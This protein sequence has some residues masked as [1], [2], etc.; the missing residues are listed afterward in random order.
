MTND[1]YTTMVDVGFNANVMAKVLTTAMDNLPYDQ[2]VQELVDT[3]YFSALML[4]TMLD[5][6]QAGQLTGRILT[7]ALY[8]AS[9]ANAVF[10]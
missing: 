4:M 8:Q 9:K 6:K 1:N 10:V 2:A 7:D 3:M 5:A